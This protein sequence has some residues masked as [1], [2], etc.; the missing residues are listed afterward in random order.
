MF[1]LIKKSFKQSI[2]ILTILLGVM[3]VFAFIATVKTAE[4]PALEAGDLFK[5]PDN[6]AVYLLNSDMERMYFPH[7]SVYKTWYSDFSAVIEIPNTCVDNYLTPSAPP[8]GVNYRPGSKL[9]KVQ[10]SPSVYVVEPGNKK[11]KLGSEAVATALYG[12]DWASK[13]V[14]IADVFWP[15]YIATG[16]EISETKL[17]NGMLVKVEGGMVYEIKDNLRY[18]VDGP[19]RDIADVQVVTPAV[20]DSVAEAGSS[21]AVSNVYKDPTQI[22]TAPPAPKEEL[23]I[24]LDA[25]EPVSSGRIRIT[26]ATGESTNPSIA[27]AGSNFGLV[28]ED[29]RA[30]EAEIF[31]VLLDENGQKLSGD[32]QISYT[33]ELASVNPKIVWNGS[34]FAVVYT[35]YSVG[36]AMSDKLYFVRLDSS[37]ARVGSIVE[38]ASEVD[39]ANPSIAWDGGGYGVIWRKPR[40]SAAKTY[41]SYIKGDGTIAPAEKA[42]DKQEGVEKSEEKK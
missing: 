11:S 6:S 22:E 9:I 15:N 31:F 5:V 40:T 20:L 14:D 37:G 17:H 23:K 10:I 28:W 38:V 34:E 16:D 7:A 21:V 27:W 32:V 29:K 42:E 8:Y 41:F 35:E 1:Y 30:G 24:I 33:P 25:K 26:Q 39:Q 2:S 13:V 4:C 18:Q 12:A 3:A 19:V 36:A